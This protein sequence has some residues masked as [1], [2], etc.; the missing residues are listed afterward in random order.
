MILGF[1]P[2]LWTQPPNAVS[3]LLPFGLI[4]L[5]AH[6]SVSQCEA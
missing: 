3:S 2:L 5:L 4:C 6:F 1:A